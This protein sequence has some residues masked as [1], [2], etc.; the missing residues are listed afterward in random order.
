MMNGHGHGRY[1]TQADA[2]QNGKDKEKQTLTLSMWKDGSGKAEVDGRML[3]DFIRFIDDTPHGRKR[4]IRMLR[5][6]ADIIEQGT[7]I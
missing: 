3:N 5:D 1:V 2:Y 4:V 7:A 6:A